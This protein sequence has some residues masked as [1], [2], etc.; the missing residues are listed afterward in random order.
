MLLPGGELMPCG[1]PA[2]GGEFAPPRLPPPMRERPGMPGE[3]GPW[4]M[5]L[6]LGQAARGVEAGAPYVSSQLCKEDVF[7]WEG[8]GR[9]PPSTAT[10]YMPPAERP[11]RSQCCHNQIAHLRRMVA[12]RSSAE[13]G[14]VPRDCDSLALASVTAASAAAAAACAASAALA[15]AAA[16]SASADA[17]P[18]LPAAAARAGCAWRNKGEVRGIGVRK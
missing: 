1:L 15:C 10:P 3:P 12:N 13:L 14:P 18:S 16:A 6:G 11:I 9:F 2:P 8:A 4:S 17:C 7:F 5:L